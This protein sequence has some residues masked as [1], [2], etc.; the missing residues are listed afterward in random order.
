MKERQVGAESFPEDRQKDRHG[1]GNG[2]FHN[3]TNALKCQMNF[4]KIC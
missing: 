1:A 4:E 3:F 2:G